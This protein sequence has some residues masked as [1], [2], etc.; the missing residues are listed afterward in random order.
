VNVTRYDP[1]QVWTFDLRLLSPTAI[2]YLNKI[3]VGG[4]GSAIGLRVRVVTDFYVISEVLGIGDGQTNTWYLTKSYQRPGVNRQYDRR[5]IK[6]VVNAHL[7]SG[8]P[9][10]YEPDGVTQRTIPS[11]IAA[12]LGVPNFTIYLNDTPQTTG[13]TINNTNGKIIFSSPPGSGV[14]VSWSG[15]FDTPM[16]FLQNQIPLKAD[17]ASEARG[18]QMVEIIGAEL[19][20][21]P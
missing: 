3:W 5:I 6:P 2:E 16:R 11:V 4:F 9:T 12:Q 1:Q 21:N 15:E 17:V 10:L 20:I 18:V 7:A 19:G 14:E 8:C 13:Y